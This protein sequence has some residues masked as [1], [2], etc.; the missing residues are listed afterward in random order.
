MKKKHRKHRKECA[1]GSYDPA[2]SGTEFYSAGPVEKPLVDNARGSAAH[3]EYKTG[4]HMANA[5]RRAGKMDPREKMAL[6]AIL[7]SAIMILLMVIA[8]FMLWKGIGL[9][10]ESILLGHIGN[11]DKSP[12]LQEVEWVE[13]FDIQNQDSPERFAQR[14]ALWKEA[15]RLVHSAEALLQ[16]NI[17]DQAID[18]CQDALRRNPAHRGA[19]EQLG[20]MYYAS[21]NHI[22]AVNAYIRLL[23]I[24]P[25]HPRIQKRLIEALYAFGD[26]NAVRHMAEWHFEKNVHDADIQ[27][28]LANA[29]YAQESFE[30]AAEAY[31][32]VSRDF[33][34]DIQSREQQ[35]FAY[36]QTGQYEKALVP[37]A[38]L[39]KNNFRNPAYYK[40]ISVCNAQLG[41]VDDTVL[42]L[43]RA[44]Q[45]F[46]QQVVLA[47]FQDPQLDPVREE[48]VFQALVDRVGGEE[49]RRELEMLAE[50]EKAL[51]KKEAD[52]EPQLEMPVS[53]LQ[54]EA[55]SRPRKK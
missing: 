21:G 52:I 54:D 2:S 25:S 40:Q 16:H 5:K 46:G 14:I 29:L 10:E 17:H 42:F 15:E 28:Y 49:F 23:S 33:P 53:K 26:Y 41:R 8:F 47:M 50:R 30:A 48:R 12:V 34:K 43:G 39:R 6:I 11:S 55:L 24:D 1:A 3:R 31:D 27:R 7:K 18:L 19:L 4:R 38:E 32:R 20:K 35:V 44:A 45:L 36:M 22:E 37:L 9:Y 51:E 13:D